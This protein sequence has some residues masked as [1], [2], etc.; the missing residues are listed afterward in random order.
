[1][2]TIELFSHKAVHSELCSPSVWRV[3]KKSFDNP[4]KCKSN[5][6][7]HCQKHLKTVVANLPSFQAE[8]LLQLRT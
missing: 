2:S 8:P 6:D 1:M 3:V 5:A 7:P 4:P